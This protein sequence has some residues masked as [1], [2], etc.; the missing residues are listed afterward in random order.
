ME[1]N[2]NP[3]INAGFAASSAIILYASSS[4]FTIRTIGSPCCFDGLKL[5]ISFWLGPFMK[6]ENKCRG[7]SFFRNGIG[8]ITASS[9]LNNALAS[10]CAH[11]LNSH[12]SGLIVITIEIV[13]SGDTL[14]IESIILFNGSSSS[15]LKILIG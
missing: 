13:S 7:N 8:F 9:F 5:S 10:F 15:C 2:I 14:P 11:V 3:H 1:T 6:N 12:F 4:A